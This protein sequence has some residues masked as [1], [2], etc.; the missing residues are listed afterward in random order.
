[1]A[2]LNATAMA[3]LAALYPESGGT[4]VYGRKRLGSFWGYL[5]GWS[6][7]I[8]KMASCAA[9]ALTFGYY[10]FP[11]FPKLAAVLAVLSLTT[12]NF[13]GI[14]KTASATKVILIIVLAILAIIVLSAQVGGGAKIERLSGFG[15]SGLYGILQSAGMM[16]FAFAGYARL[17]TLGEEV[18][19]P[20]KTI[21][22]AVIISLGITLF[23]YLA[24]ILTTLMSVDAH[25]LET[26]KSPLTLVVQS[27]KFSFLSPLV[28]VGAT[29]ACLGVLLSLLAGV[30]RTVYAMA[31]NSDLPKSLSKVHEEHKTPY[32]AETFIASVLIAIISISDIRS[33]IGFSSFAILIY[34]AIANVAA[35]TLK[36]EERLWPKWVSILGLTSCLAIAFSLPVNSIVGGLLLFSVGILFHWLWNKMNK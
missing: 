36:T 15:E 1:V 16:F 8:G 33:A 27:G 6:F 35:I 23:V 10:A 30:S 20:E 25:V 14:K 31:L 22:K 24:V 3:Q 13:F 9:M 32:V 34:Y 5:A 12:I 21:P 2:F 11:D 7:V 28:V 18:V 19:S 26:S 29:L 4:Y 17:A